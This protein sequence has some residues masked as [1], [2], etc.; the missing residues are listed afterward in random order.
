MRVPFISIT[1]FMTREQVYQMLAIAKKHNGKNKPLRK[2]GVGVMMSYKTLHEIP[3]KWT[4]VFPR[5]YQVSGIFVRDD[6]CFNVLHYADYQEQDFAKSL[7]IARSWAGYFLDAIQ[8]DMI[9]PNPGV[10][11]EFRDKN[12]KVQLILQIGANAFE[13]IEND[14]L[15]LIKRLKTYGQALDY[16]LLDK[17]MGQGKLLNANGLMPY[18]EILSIERPDLGLIVAGGL[19]PETLHLAHPIIEKF[20]NISLDAQARL[21]PS[22]SALDPIDWDLASLYLEQAYQLF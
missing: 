17:S 13:A 12:P 18:L 14:P 22:Q 9:W 5:N 19:G 20:P 11:A 15:E 10:L 1:D 6:L 3:S 21:R 7:D 2:L 4:G 16:V 8:L